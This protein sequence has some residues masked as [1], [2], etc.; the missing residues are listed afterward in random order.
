M[1]PQESKMLI[2]IMQAT[3]EPMKITAGKFGV[4]SF[5]YFMKVCI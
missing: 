3:K 4:L 5:E 2:N 1:R